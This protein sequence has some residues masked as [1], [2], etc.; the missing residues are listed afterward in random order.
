MCLESKYHTFSEV[1]LGVPT[2]TCVAGI[3][4]VMNKAANIARWSGIIFFVFTLIGTI[5]SFALVFRRKSDLEEPL[6]H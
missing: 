1:T 6:L 5:A 4:K 2:Q 3:N